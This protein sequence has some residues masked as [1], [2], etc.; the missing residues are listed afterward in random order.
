MDRALGLVRLVQGIA[1]FKHKRL[2]GTSN[3]RRQL[4]EGNETEAFK[5][6]NFITRREDNKISVSRLKLDECGWC[7]LV[8]ESCSGRG[9][10]YNCGCTGKVLKY[11]N[12]GGMN[13]SYVIGFV[14]WF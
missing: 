2:I 7:L 1:L 12:Y 13:L 11:A 10:V 3:Y 6:L 8:F 9:V 4:V 5:G 14:G